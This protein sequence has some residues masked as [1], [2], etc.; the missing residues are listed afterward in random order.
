LSEKDFVAATLACFWPSVLVEDLQN[1]AGV[2]AGPA[3]EASQL[4][5]A[6]GLVAQQDGQKA[7]SD[8]QADAFGLGGGS[9]LGLPVGIDD[10]GIAPLGL[11]QVQAFLQFG[12]LLLQS[13]DL[14]LLRGDVEVAQ[15]GVGFA[16]QPLRACEKIGYIMVSDINNKWSAG[17]WLESETACHVMGDG[18]PSDNSLDLFDASNR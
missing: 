8:R 1:G 16:I 12:G 4:G 17:L 18:E 9:E 11:E 5:D 3:A 13:V 2:Q 6:G 7:A 10:D 14:L 15:D